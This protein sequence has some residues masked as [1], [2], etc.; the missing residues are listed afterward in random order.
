MS[1]YICV[2]CGTQYAETAGPPEHCK[3]CQDERQYIGA[4]GQQWT[5]LAEL[6]SRHSNVIGEDEAG[7]VGYRHESHVRYRPEGAAYTG[8]GRQRDVGMHKPD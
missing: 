3:I 8:T 6:R 1:N 5:T 4:D 2:T 7:L